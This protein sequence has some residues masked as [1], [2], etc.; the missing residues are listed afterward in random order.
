MAPA[1]GGDSWPL[2]MPSLLLHG[3]HAHCPTATSPTEGGGDKAVSLSKGLLAPQG[4]RCESASALSSLILLPRPSDAEFW[5]S[6]HAHYAL[7]HPDFPPS[8][9]DCSG[10]TTNFLFLNIPEKRKTPPMTRSVSAT[11]LTHFHGTER[12]NNQILGLIALVFPVGL[13]EPL[14][15]CPDS[16]QRRP[17]A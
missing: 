10:R 8:I 5:S 2:H 11:L 13:P 4:R 1:D 14:F 15:R 16:P 9:P 3:S 12:T 6:S 17:P 7:G